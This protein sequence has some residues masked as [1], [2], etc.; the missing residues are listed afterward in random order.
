MS[1]S[2]DT[3]QARRREL[4]TAITTI[5]ARIDEIDQLLALD[6]PEPRRPGRPRIVRTDPPDEAA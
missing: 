3:L 4:V 2:Q 1:V 6:E 5:Q